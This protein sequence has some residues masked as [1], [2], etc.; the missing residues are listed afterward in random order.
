[1]KTINLIRS[2]GTQDRPQLN[3]KQLI[4]L[5][6]LLAAGFALIAISSYWSHQ[7]NTPLLVFLSFWLFLFFSKRTRIAPSSN[8]TDSN[9]RLIFGEQNLVCRDGDAT[10]WHIPYTR[11]SHVST[12]PWTTGDKSYQQAVFHTRDGDSFSLLAPLSSANVS[13]ITAVLK[14]Y[15]TVQE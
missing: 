6:L 13:D 8:R 4:I 9:Y 1:M 7:L 11:I 2:F 5:L 12:S 3:R 15:L 14:P 10:L